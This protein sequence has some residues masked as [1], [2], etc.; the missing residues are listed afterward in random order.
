MWGNLQKHLFQQ[1]YWL[2]IKKI[3]ELSAIFFVKDSQV[4]KQK[5]I[6]ESV[7]ELIKEGLEDTKIFRFNPF[8]IEVR[9]WLARNFSKEN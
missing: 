3:K 2:T 9:L 5:M 6:F 1:V 8:R 4:R 7:L